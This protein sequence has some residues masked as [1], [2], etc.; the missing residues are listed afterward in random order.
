[1][2][3]EHLPGERSDPVDPRHRAAPVE[4]Q[5]ARRQAV[6]SNEQGS[7]SRDDALTLRA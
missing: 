1:M 3:L 2:E 4:P 7:G 6:A 5:Q